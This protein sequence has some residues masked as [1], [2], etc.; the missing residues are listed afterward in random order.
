MQLVNQFLVA[1]SLDWSKE[2]A[3]FMSLPETQSP[4][5]TNPGLSPDGPGWTRDQESK[6]KRSPPRSRLSTESLSKLASPRYKSR[7][8]K[9]SHARN[10]GHEQGHNCRL[11]WDWQTGCIFHRQ[12]FSCAATCAGVAPAK[13]INRICSRRR[14]EPYLAAFCPAQHRT[15]IKVQER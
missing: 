12:P 10:A 6:R 8:M 11:W 7:C 15:N 5:M 3:T 9:P 1:K 2:H 13:S 4:Q 14:L